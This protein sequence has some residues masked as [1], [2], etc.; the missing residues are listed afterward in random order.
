VPKKLLELVDVHTMIERVPDKHLKA[1]LGAH[2]ASRFVC[3]KGIE[4]N[5]LALFEWM[6]EVQKK[7]T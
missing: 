7:H 1:I 5:E 4:T 6:H 3:E 2:I